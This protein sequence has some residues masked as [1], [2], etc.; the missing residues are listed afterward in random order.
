MYVFFGLFK[1]IHRGILDRYFCFLRPW[2]CVRFFLFFSR[3]DPRKAGVVVGPAVG[4]VDRVAGVW[5]IGLRARRSVNERLVLPSRV[6]PLLRS[7]SFL[8]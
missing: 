6:V 3:P 5:R 1:Y 4:D 7:V 8:V 2:S